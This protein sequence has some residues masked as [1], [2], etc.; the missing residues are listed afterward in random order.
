VV[1]RGPQYQ[2]MEVRGREA[3]IHFEP[4]TVS[5]GLTTHDG[6]PPAFFMEAG[7]DHVFH[8]ATAEIVTDSVIRLRCPEV[9]K[10]VAVRYA[11]TNYP[12]TNLQNGSGWPAVPFRT[13]DWPENSHR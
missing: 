1:Y 5:G 11:F 10:P 12:V 6:N 9:K 8:P 2:Y 7:A 3:L 4:G 13:D